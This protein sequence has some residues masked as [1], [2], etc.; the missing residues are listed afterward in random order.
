MGLA[1]FWPAGLLSRNKIL[2]RK[3]QTIVNKETYAAKEARDEIFQQKQRW[4][5][6]TRTTGVINRV[7]VYHATSLSIVWF[8]VNNFLRSKF[9]HRMSIFYKQIG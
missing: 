2:Q 7:G 9:F 1:R 8:A 4:E 6:E 5:R 3:R